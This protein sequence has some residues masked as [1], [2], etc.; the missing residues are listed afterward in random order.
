MK[1]GQQ[2][3]SFAVRVGRTSFEFALPKGG[4]L[5]T[6]LQYLPSVSLGQKTRACSS[7]SS[8]RH[9]HVAHDDAAVNS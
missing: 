3:E 6:S 2:H 8:I 9:A 5:S 4:C 7:W 1:G